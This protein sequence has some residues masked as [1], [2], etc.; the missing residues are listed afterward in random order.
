VRLPPA[1]AIAYGE[2]PT[3][4]GNL[5]LP[6]GNGPFPLVVLVH[7]GFWRNGWD[8]TTLTPLAVDLA[9]AGFAAWNVEYRCVGAPG[10]GW[11]GTFADVAAAFDHVPGLPSVAAEP[12]V[13]VGHSAGGHL[14]LWLATRGGLPAGAPGAGPAVVP[15]AVVAIG[16][17]CDLAAAQREG[18][19]AGAAGALLGGEPDAV[20]DRCALASPAARLPLG[21]PQLVVVGGRDDVVPA[22]HG[23]AYVEAARAAGDSVDLLELPDADH[24]DL[25]DEAHP[26][27]QAVV[28]RIRELGPGS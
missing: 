24:F 16:A 28:A 20:P 4:V 21:V 26:A 9:A 7:G 17:V 3:Q 6:S 23:R 22:D 12:P 10:G 14:A 27:W 13:V 18:L 19:G 11:P 5:H 2:H 8:R 25:V 15:R 1:P